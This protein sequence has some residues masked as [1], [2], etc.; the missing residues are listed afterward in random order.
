VPAGSW[1]LRIEQGAT[2]S[3]T[4]TSND[5]G[6]SVDW[7]GWTARAQ[8]RTEARVGAELLLDLATYLTVATTRITLTIPASVTA[9]LTRSGRWDLELVNGAPTPT[10]IRFLEGKALISPEVTQ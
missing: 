5:D 7:T 10:V 8:I 9:L 1:D 6:S 2:F 4:Y 3:E